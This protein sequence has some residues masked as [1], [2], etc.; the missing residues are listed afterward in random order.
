MAFVIALPP[1]RSI[2]PFLPSPLALRPTGKAVAGATLEKRL[3]PSLSFSH[4]LPRPEQKAPLSING[5]QTR[6]EPAEDSF[7][8]ERSE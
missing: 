4:F 7:S 3:P 6:P 8:F 1:S 2:P 5:S